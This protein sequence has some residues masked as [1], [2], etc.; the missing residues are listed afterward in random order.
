VR[1]LSIPS[2]ADRVVQTAA[3]QVLT[4]LLDAGFSEASFGYR[5]GR[6]VQQAVRRGDFL[7]RDGYRWVVDADIDDYFASVPHERLLERLGRAVKD[8]RVVDLVAR[9][10]DAASETDRG[11]PQGAPISPLLANL[12]L[13][14]VDD[15]IEATGVRLVRFADDFLIL[16]R[17]EAAA[18]DAREHVADLLAAQGLRLDP[19]KTRIA[20]F[21]D[22]VRFLGHLF[23]RS[24]VLREAGYDDGSLDLPPPDA[25]ERP[26]VAPSDT[27][28]A[29]PWGVP[30]AE[31]VPGLRV[32]YL[33]EAGRTLDVRN[34]AFVV[35][36]AEEE[37][38]A[39]QPGRVDRIDI[40]PRVEVSMRAIRHALN[41]AVPLTFCDGHGATQGTLA[42]EPADRAA[43]HLAQAACVLDEARRL[44][45]ARR[46]ADGRMRNQRALLRRLNRRRKRPEVAQA[47][48]KI[49]RLTRLLA[50]QTEPAGVMG[51]E[52]R[53]AA[54][55]WPALGLCLEH[56][57]RLVTRVRRPPPDP[58]NLALSYLATL[59]T[60]DIAAMALRQGLHPGFGALHA[61]QDGRPAL[62]LDLVEEFR[63][64]LV[65][66]LAVY[67]FNNRML[68]DGMFHRG[69]GGTRLWS[70]GVKALV[71]GYEA[72]MDR[73][74]KSPRSG[75]ELS[76]RRLIDEQLVALVRHVEGVEP[77][78]AYEMGY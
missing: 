38:F 40:G 26:V 47:A 70:P 10:L 17:D 19:A 20:G 50:R 57:W 77:Y 39:V 52:G 21:E 34:E 25:A 63:A 33:T 65:E 62:A 35:R 58:V 9:W 71:R 41:E 3:A 32:L 46:F 53:A 11:L 16:C 12:Y 15:A 5:P 31:R 4:P 55:Y 51:V 6:S 59:L 7:R 18:E 48:Q 28:W 73:A 37:I 64:P 54:L 72:W 27:T 74:V 44:D 43:V 23:V 1:L 36:E 61:T 68:V 66:G 75:L 29:G 60:R 30:R 76:W 13:D 78:R 67:L 45:L 56:G 24:L 42:V 14:E 22:S 2:I 49:G 69:D 8:E